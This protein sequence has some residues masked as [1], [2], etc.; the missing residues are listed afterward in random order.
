MSMEKKLEE[1]A[2][3]AFAR[4]RPTAEKR[5]GSI[6]PAALPMSQISSAFEAYR[7]KAPGSRQRQDLPSLDAA[8]TTY[9]KAHRAFW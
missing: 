6:T 4:Y 9:T 3:K 8:R 5:G 2:E 7:L 1:L